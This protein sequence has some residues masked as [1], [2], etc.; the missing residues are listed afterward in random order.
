MK[1]VAETTS[2]SRRQALGQFLTASP[3]AGFIASLFGPLPPTVRLLDAGA[4][5]GALTRALATRARAS[6]DGVGAIE[7]TLYKI[8]PDILA[9]LSANMRECQRLCGLAG[10]RFTFRIHGP[11]FREPFTSKEERR[12]LVACVFDPAEVGAEWIGLENHLNYFHAGGRGLDRELAWGLWAF[13]N[14][15][16]VDQYFRR[17]SGHT[18]V[19]ATDLRALA[20]PNGETLR[21]MGRETK[22][23]D[24]GQEGIDQLVAKHLE[25]RQLSRPAAQGNPSSAKS[26]G[27][28]RSGRPLGGSEGVAQVAMLSGGTLRRRRDST[29][30]RRAGTCPRRS[31]APRH[32]RDLGSAS[33]RSQKICVCRLFV[34]A[35]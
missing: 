13:L 34:F 24:L 10:I 20:Y 18:Q 33:C 16:V 19:N 32:R 31:R 2:R 29:G 35:G 21:S 12:R 4:G 11:I 15:T 26:L 7:A 6:N 28:P 22:R 17:F 23:I 9:A 3:V 1:A 30:E 14:S 27:N 25:A 8:D 5:A